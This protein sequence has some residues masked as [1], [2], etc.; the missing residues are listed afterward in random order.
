MGN[1]I[2][3]EYKSFEDIKHTDESGA[4]FWLARELCPV[5]QYAQWRNFQGVIDKAM[6]ACRNSGFDVFDHFA[7]ASKTVAMPSKAKPKIIPDYKLSRYACYLIVQ[8]GN[9][10]KEIIAL[11][12]TYFAIQTRRQ[13]VQDYFNQLDEDNK[14]LVVRGNI[15]Q[16]NQML[17]ESAHRAGIIDNEE[18]AEFQNAGYAGLYG[19]ETVS[20]IH[21]RKQLKPKDKIL[22]FMN[23]SELSANLFRITLAD[24]K[25]KK[26][27]VSTPHDAIE[28]HSIA[29]QEV[30]GAIIRA[31]AILPE[32]QPTPDKSV[33]QIAAEQI[34]RIKAEAKKKPLMLDEDYEGFEDDD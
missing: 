24:D 30:R 5:L 33:K 17:A 3:K 28:A 31:D 15:T 27:N 10:R 8:N 7:D 9:P 26:G 4:E 20:E 29:G 22:D 34:A 14:R 23:S 12:Q 32:D 13:E 6:L 11:G 21:A 25:M 1:L 2:A 19:G 18:F 16:W